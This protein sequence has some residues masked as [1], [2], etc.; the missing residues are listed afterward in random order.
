MEKKKTGLIV[1]IVIMSLLIVGLGGYI[2]YNQFIA[3]NTV[4]TP[5]DNENNDEPL[6]NIIT[7]AEAME[8]YD[9]GFDFVF[10]P[11]GSER[12]QLEEETTSI[13]QNDKQQLCHRVINYQEALTSLFSERI[14][15]NMEVIPGAE[16]YNGNYYFCAGGRGMMGYIGAIL[17]RQNETSTRVEFIARTKF[18]RNVEAEDGEIVYQE[19][20][21]VLVHENGRWVIDYFA[22]AIWKG[23]WSNEI[24]WQQ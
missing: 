2:I 3:D 23:E 8:I 24:F 4:G 13:Y 18:Y 6:E 16:Y 10:N 1:I 7:E 12:Y 17:T 22:S 11:T 15:Q 21:F 20:P 19:N 14:V 5:Q 9:E